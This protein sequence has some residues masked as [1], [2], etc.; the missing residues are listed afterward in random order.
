[1][2]TGESDVSTTPEPTSGRSRPLI[3]RYALGGSVLA[4][5]AGGLTREQETT[6]TR[7][8]A[9]SVAALVA[10]LLDAD[11][12]YADRMKRVIAEDDPVLVA[13]DQDAWAARLGYDAT[14]VAESLALFTAN[15]RRT[16][17]V[18]RTL[19]DADFARA[20]R[21]TADGRVNL[22]G[23]LATVT[24]HLDHH[25]RILYTKRANLGVAIGPRYP[26]QDLP[27]Y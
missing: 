2:R 10:H 27:T 4:Y 13:F 3:E 5:A 12:V 8:G 14:D 23:L 9:W 16:A 11:L 20:G 1:M 26:S 15:R 24:N 6:P 7:P 17:A 25:L 21:H 22:A 18:L 19:P